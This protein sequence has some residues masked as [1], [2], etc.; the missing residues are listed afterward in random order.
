MKK[1]ERRKLTLSTLIKLMLIPLLKVSEGEKGEESVKREL[2]A[3]RTVSAELRSLD[4]LGRDSLK[5]DGR[6]RRK[7]CKREEEQ[8]LRTTKAGL[9]HGYST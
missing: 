5:L 8:T 6:G 9:R 7:K 1:K 2:P 4:E 3:E